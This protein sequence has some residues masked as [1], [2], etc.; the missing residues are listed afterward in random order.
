[1]PELH[2]LLV[3]P[4]L[5]PTFNIAS[6]SAELDTKLYDLRFE[7][8]SARDLYAYFLEKVTKTSTGFVS[9]TPQTFTNGQKFNS[10]RKILLDNFTTLDVYCFDNVPD[11]IF[12][13]IK[14]G[15][16]NTNTANS[17]RAG[18]IVAMQVQSKK[19]FRITPLLRWRVKERQEFLDSIDC[20]LTE[21]VVVYR[22]RMTGC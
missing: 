8:S 9:I 10:L 14:F 15:S 3:V 22:L 16:K 19:V 5:Y 13:G 20:F 17:T 1:M 6:A 2:P 7:T 12:R 11:N 18:I 4:K 21:V